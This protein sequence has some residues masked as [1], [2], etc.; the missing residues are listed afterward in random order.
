V[1]WNQ[2]P[3]LPFFALWFSI[4][5]KYIHLT[6]SQKLFHTSQRHSRMQGCDR[7][8]GEKCFSTTTGSVTLM[9]NGG[10]NPAICASALIKHR[11]LSELRQYTFKKEL[12]IGLIRLY[13]ANNISIWQIQFL[14]GN[15]HKFF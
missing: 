8:G 11:S 5:N 10:Y 2:L 15:I 4:L 14:V 9:D 13:N 3:K 6:K 1:D 7:G 12:S